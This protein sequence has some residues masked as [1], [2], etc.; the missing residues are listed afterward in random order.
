MGKRQGSTRLLPRGRSWQHEEAGI[1]PESLQNK[2]A[3]ASRQ[4]LAG[5]LRFIYKSAGIVTLSVIVRSFRSDTTRAASEFLHPR[6]QLDLPRPG[7]AG[8][9]DEVHV[10]LGDGV[11]VEQAVGIVRGLG[12]ARALDAAVDHD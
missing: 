3:C 1:R 5:L 2:G 7:A 6:P 10:A 4:I 8:L 12:A 9:M 11:G